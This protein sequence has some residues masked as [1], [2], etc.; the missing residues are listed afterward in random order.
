MQITPS[1]LAFKKRRRLSPLQTS[2][3]SFRFTSGLHTS[4]GEANPHTLELVIE[5]SIDGQR[6]NFSPRRQQ[7]RREKQT[8]AR[9][10]FTFFSKKRKKNDFLFKI[11]KSP[12]EQSRWLD[13]R[14]VR[15][16]IEENR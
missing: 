5:D 3:K 10:D 7:D 1:S 16:K 8:A 4:S 6:E 15:A 11:Q 2:L 14:Y 9:N 12:R 13:S